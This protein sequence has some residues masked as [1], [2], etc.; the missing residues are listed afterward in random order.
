VATNVSTLVI[1]FL[2]TG[3]LTVSFANADPFG[4][5]VGLNDGN[6]FLN[7]TASLVTDAQGH[8]LDGART[9]N[10]GGNGHDE[11]WRLFGDFLGTRSVDA[12]DNQQF[13][14]AFGS[15]SGQANYFWFMDYDL[16]LTIDSSDKTQFRNRL[17]TSLN[18]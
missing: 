2:A 11:F 8:P 17:F 3:N 5:K 4:N 10:Y 1:R 9:G 7:T 15:S 6:Y 13:G 18:S 16:S 12:R 14:Q